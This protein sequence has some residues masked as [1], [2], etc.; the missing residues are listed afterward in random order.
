MPI[1]RRIIQSIMKNVSLGGIVFS[2]G[3]SP[4]SCFVL[5]TGLNG[6]PGFAFIQDIMVMNELDETVYITPIV[7]YHAEQ[8]DFMELYYDKPTWPV[9]RRRH[10]PI[11]PGKR[12]ILKYDMDDEQFTE[13]Y[14][15]T[16]QW[17]KV[18]IVDANPHPVDYY[19]PKVDM[20]N[21]DG[22]L[23]LTEPSQKIIN[24]M[25]KSDKNLLWVLF[26]VYFSP[27]FLIPSILGFFY[28]RRRLKKEFS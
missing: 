17:G 7:T 24:L 27:I 2:I 18:F 12:R 19:P 22:D 4:L 6:L 11:E 5:A 10:I 26:L 23:E 21:I 13:L 15:K 25:N 14:I 3:L 9:L 8:K 20:I 28:F 1:R 16:D